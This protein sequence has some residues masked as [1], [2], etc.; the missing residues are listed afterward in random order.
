MRDAD[1]TPD[2][3]FGRGLGTR[4]RA[5]VPLTGVHRYS[6]R[7]RRGQRSWTNSRTQLLTGRRRT[8]RRR[9]DTR[10]SCR[11]HRCAARTNR[12]KEAQT[13]IRNAVSYTNCRAAI[14]LIAAD[15][16]APRG[17][18]GCSAVG[19]R[20]GRWRKRD[21]AGGL[22]RHAVPPRTRRTP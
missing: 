21:V 8:G 13:D 12:Q 3:H 9:T 10:N 2:K 16:R 20:E 7:K 5:R 11:C 1:K 15:G 14:G 18:G 17:N 4:A 19:G 22:C 6:A